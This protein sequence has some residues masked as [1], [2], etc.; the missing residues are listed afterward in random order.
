MSNEAKK[1]LS[2]KG[3]KL[4]GKV[5][6]LEPGEHVLKINKVYLKQFDFMKKDEAYHLVL[7]METKPIPYLC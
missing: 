7:D 5:K 4:G 6:H 1:K 3:I 2:T